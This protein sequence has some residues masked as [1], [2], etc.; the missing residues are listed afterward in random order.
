VLQ[1][2]RKRYP[3]LGRFDAAL[4][5]TESGGWL[6]GGRH[7]CFCH[8]SLHR[9]LCQVCVSPLRGG[10]CHQDMNRHCPRPENIKSTVTPYTF[11]VPRHGR[12]P[13]ARHAHADIGRIQTRRAATAT[14]THNEG[15]RDRRAE[16]T[17]CVL[18]EYESG[19]F[20]DA[21]KEYA[22]VE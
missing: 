5:A 19:E 6:V 7:P 10:P 20:T 3:N 17:I 4:A 13:H 14:A 9:K 12:F 15:G 11:P 22:W 2:C 8:A 16:D 21:D 18:S 1:P